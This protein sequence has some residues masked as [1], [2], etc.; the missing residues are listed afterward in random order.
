MSSCS[1]DHVKP[2]SSLSF[3]SCFRA[4]T[5]Q[6]RC[7]NCQSRLGI[8]TE[9]DGQK[10]VKHG[11]CPNCGQKITIGASGKALA[12]VVPLIVVLAWLTW[13]WLPP[14]I[15]GLCAGVLIWF[16]AVKLDK[17]T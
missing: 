1:D 17:A 3:F 13:N 10:R 16:T 12:V 11:A 4:Q 5:M 2:R 6:L 9:S 8:F 14:A 7:P 15:L